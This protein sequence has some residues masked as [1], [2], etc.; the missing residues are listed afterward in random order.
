MNPLDEKVPEYDLTEPVLDGIAI[1]GMSGRFPGANSVAEF[2]RNQ[3]AGVEAISHFRLEELELEGSR[4]SVE[5]PNY[6]RSR[7][8]LRDIE[9]FDAEFFGILPKDALVMD[10]Q[11]RLFLECCSEAFEDAGHDPFQYPGSIGVIAGSSYGSYFLSQLCRQPGF[12]ENFLDNY[13]IGNYSSMMGNQPEFLPTRV[14]YKFN[15]RGPSY[16]IQTACSTSLLAVCQACQSLLTYQSDMMLA[17][18]V[19]I[20]LPQKRGYVYVEGGMGSADGHCKPF[21]DDAQGTVFG[22]G[23]GVVLLKR[24]ED[25]ISDGDHV[26]AVIRGFGVNNDGA[27]KIGYTA[28]SVEGQANVI[29]MAQQ[30][31]GVDAR[32][33]EYVEAHG[34]ATPLGDPIELAALTKAFRTSTEESGFCT[35]GT[36]KANVGH[37]DIAAGITGLIHATQVVQH[38]Q[39]PPTLHFK[40]PTEKFDFASSPFRVTA[41]GGSWVS[42]GPRRAAVSAF[43]VG[44]TNAHLIL[45]QAPQQQPSPSDRR[46]QLLSLSA[47]SPEA[48]GAAA[49][50]LADYL[51]SN[52]ETPLSDAAYTLHLGR[53]AFDH[54]LAVTADTIDAAVTA[55][56]ASSKL[57][58][59]REKRAGKSKAAYM[60]P[61]QGS[62]HSNMGR[63]LYRSEP[64]FRDAFDTCARIL[65][66]EE[67]DLIG[68]L[69]QDDDGKSSFD[70]TQTY[71]AQ[72]AIFAIEYALS[73]LWIS[74][75]VI[76]EAMIGHSIG[77]FVAACL[78]EVLS[79]ED[80]LHLVAIR[81]RLMQSLPAGE[82]L[83]VRL[84][85][86]E[87]SALL[88][89]GLD[90][91]AANAP[92]LCVVSG[93]SD[94][95]ASLQA[96]LSSREVAHRKLYTSHAFHS[97]MMEPILDEFRRE[98]EKVSLSAPTIRYVS[99][100]TGDW[101]THSQATSPAYWTEHIRKTVRFSQGISTLLELP[102]VALLEVGPGSA[103]AT[104]ARQHVAS[105]APCLI[106]SSLSDGNTEHTEDFVLLQAVGAL[107]S[108]GVDVSWE[109]FY[110]YER[111]LRVSLPTYPF[112][113]KRFWFND[114]QRST[115]DAA[116]IQAQEVNFNAK[117]EID[118]E[119]IM[120][121]SLKMST[122][123]TPGN[124]VPRS[125]FLCG[126]IA[127]IFEELSGLTISEAEQDASF[128]ELGFDSLFLTQASQALQSKFGIKITFRQLLGDVSSL[129]AL[130]AFVD[131]QLPAGSF[132]SPAETAAEIPMEKTGSQIAASASVAQPA[133]AQ[134]AYLIN[135]APLTS[136][137]S[138]LEQLMRDQLQV[139]NQ[140]FSQ[141]M[142]VLQGVAVQPAAVMPS[143]AQAPAGTVSVAAPAVPSAATAAASGPAPKD[144]HVELKGYT[145]FKP[146][147]KSVSGEMTPRQ[148]EHISKLTAFYNKRTATSKQKTQESRPYLAD[149]RVVAGFRVQ[150]KE[151]IYPIITSSSKGSRLWDLDGNEYVDILNGFGPIMLGHRPDFVEE[152]IN[153]QLHEGFEIGPQ[154]ILAGEVAK[155]L[156]EMTGN[157]RATFCNTGSE[158]VMAAMRL[159]RTLSGKSKVVF[160][161]GDYHGMFDEVLVKGFKRGGLP[162]SAP[163]APGIPRES[164]SNM[165]VLD[166]GTDDSLEWIRSHAQELA[167]V[168]VEPVQ[169]RHPNLQPIEFLKEIR[170]ITEQN[171]VCLIFDE[172]VTGFR[173]HPGGCQAL[174]GI[175]ADLATYGKVLAGGMPMG[176]LAG[177]ARYMDAL[178]GGMWQYGDDSFPEV[179]VTFF[180]GTFVRHP[181]AMAACAAVLKHLKEQGPE[182]QQRLTTR[183][184]ALIARLNT[185]LTENELPIHIETFASFFYFSFPSDYRFSSIFYTHLRSKGIYLLEGFP[186]FLTTEHSDEDMERVYRAFKETIA[187]MQAG[188]LLPLPSSVLSAAVEAI[189]ETAASAPITESQMEILLSAQLSSEANCS[190]NESFTLYLEGDLNQRILEDSLTNILS[191]Y[192]ALRAT[193]DPNAGIQNF[194]APAPVALPRLDLSAFAESERAEK[195]HAFLEEDSRTPF[196]LLNGPLVRMTL[197]RLSPTQHALAFTGHHA[198]CDGWSINVIL[199]ELSRTYSARVAGKAPQLDPVMPFSEY[200]RNQEK[201]FAGVEGA[202]VE[203]YWI[204]KFEVLPPLLDLPLDHARPAMKSF[205]GATF[206]RKIDL[207]TLKDLK[208][209]GAQHKCTLFVTLLSGFGALLSRLT[210]QDDIVIGVPAAG[211][212]LVEDRTLVG[213]CVNFVPMRTLP[214]EGISTAG[215]L[216]QVRKTVFDA[217]DHQN[218]TFGRLVRKLAI[219]RDPSRLPLLEVQFNL[220]KIG[221]DLNFGG[222]KV[223]VE[224]NPKSFVNFDLFVNAVEGS[225]GLTLHVD[226]N[227]NL[228]DQD[229]LALWLDAYEMLIRGIAADASQPLAH[230][231]LLTIRERD[232]ALFSFNQTESSYPTNLCVHQLFE[233]Q[234]AKTPNTR[235]LR[236]ED[237]LLTYGQLNERVNRLARYLLTHGVKAGDV[238]GI[239]MERSVAMVVSLLA[240]WKAGACYVP[241]DPTFPAE[242]LK[243]V[244]E[245][246]VNPTVLTQTAIANDLPAGNARVLKVDELWP[247]IELEDAGNL[248]LANDPAAVAYVIYT[249]GSTGR[250][251][252]VEVTQTNVV[253][254]LCSMEKIPGMT[255]KDVLV[256]VTTISFDIAAL[257]IYLPLVC[258]AELILASRAVASDGNQLLK[259]LTDAHATIM[260][261]TPITFRLLL[262]AGWTGTPAITAWCGGEAMPRDLANQLLERGIPLWNMYGPTE[263]TIWSATNRVIAED[264]PVPV[265][266]P[267]AN[268]QFYVL[269]T[270]QQLLPLGVPGELYIGGAG[271]AKGYYKRPDLTASRFVADPFSEKAGAR[272]YRTGDMVR[273]TRNGQL[274]FLGRADGQIKLRGFRIELGEIETIL[275]THPSV[276]QGVVLLRE[277]VPGDKRLVAYIIPQSDAPVETDALRRHLMGKLPDYMVPAAFISLPSFP[278]T[279]NGKIDRKALPVPAWA[280]MAQSSGYVAPSTPQ[281]ESFARIWADVLHLDQVGIADSIFELGGDSLH[282]F[283]IAARANQAGIDVK[284]RQILQHRTITAIL[285]DLTKSAAAPKLAPLTPV[286]RAKYR[287][288]QPGVPG[289]PEPVDPGGRGNR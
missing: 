125:S 46:F 77:E 243:M 176:V 178:D 134:P 241:L 171:D 197:I 110:Q 2:W 146:L 189:V 74:W 40:K 193:F 101:I 81:G 282:V 247:E 149:P 216:D 57:R 274:E 72:P 233:Q 24:L 7:S 19:S 201:H 190:F 175:R 54:R 53:R 207:Q 160:F 133:L 103:L 85:E 64:V 141:Q 126:V 283:Q 202:E 137:G 194:S 235:A 59:N 180:A 89:E 109:R 166:Y 27:G 218:Y 212:S 217:Y 276:G 254:L 246:I 143:S 129:T 38:G 84:G 56:A 87:T 8:I 152:A 118:L 26:Y 44:G 16:A 157:E 20:T 116:D 21:D 164:V 237:Q 167:A 165:V 130:A 82:M 257:E 63:E 255:S 279:A 211:Q 213:H 191:R 107:W 240:T 31:A 215:F 238:V 51:E 161:A 187:E 285:S 223:S 76:P 45:E 236:F 39:F 100:V 3:L 242:R 1:I 132:E 119:K 106:V 224:P 41:S 86:S 261:A 94:V 269:D 102:D 265:G 195:L 69:F 70:T 227:T 205:E 203:S 111:R 244:F 182:L 37:L 68:G 280:S 65:L 206:S 128:L 142:A 219:P 67:V 98:V 12:P 127:E 232:R 272:I 267:I 145:P 192:E 179:G 163:I 250:P 253:N 61:G 55:L 144:A 239:Y 58:P 226:Y 288:V 249:S 6:I 287:I 177:K 200:A 278:L 208:K 78:A 10:P 71:F 62:Q 5:R 196:D 22:S 140:L 271:V 281:E 270:L 150:W 199:D 15:L 186:C 17:G 14:A 158:A 73:Q 95:M 155:A 174:F 228:I 258:G 43:G 35:I 147:Q 170:R 222:L 135:P 169:S 36:A 120:E 91:A 80:A 113:R 230:L 50:N 183:T 4:E 32:T 97:S 260:Q 284:P 25:A 30:A 23:V 248:N 266:L 29:T 214:S 156:C 122:T 173:S 75:G 153:K 104:L 209:A 115:R 124:K 229:T 93:P 159:A 11:H 198:V 108:R 275:S 251:K 289:Q 121:E 9:Q 162:Q 117:N 96:T 185:L 262:A 188:E 286:S 18:G 123:T 225:D 49:R 90:I 220:E 92:S 148:I 105:S 172:V 204:K 60:F 184:A 52:R 48:L 34:T 273:R 210:N 33:I 66:A 136:G 264:A 252:G 221:G 256:A 88:A 245:D 181:L 28:P 234:A 259:L 47:R 139:M 263:T 114:T 42:D 99:C 13:Q 154:T 112:E 151:L 168:L 83:S 138:G 131:Q 231:P 277:D 79:L 268:T